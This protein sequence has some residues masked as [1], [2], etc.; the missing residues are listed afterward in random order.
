MR[1]YARKLSKRIPPPSLGPL[2][3]APLLSVSYHPLSI[4]TRVGDVRDSTVPNAVGNN[5]LLRYI[6]DT[7]AIKQHS[8]SRSD[9]GTRAS[10][11]IAGITSPSQANSL[12]ALVQDGNLFDNSEPTVLHRTQLQK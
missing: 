11:E 8:L 3:M 10:A 5:G 4:L 12:W 9:S 7:E 6:W 2:W 1:S